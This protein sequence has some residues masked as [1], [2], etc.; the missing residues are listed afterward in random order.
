MLGRLARQSRQ[1]SSSSVEPSEPHATMTI[2][3]R[4]DCRASACRLSTGRR[5][6]CSRPPGLDVAHQVQRPHLR[7]M[8][9]RPG[10]VVAVERV[11]CVDVAADVAVA[12]MDAGALLDALGV[13]E[14]LALGQRC[15]G[16]PGRRSSPDRTRPPARAAGTGRPRRSLRRPSFISFMRSRP[17]IVGHLLHVHELGRPC[18]SAASSSSYVISA[19]QAGLE[20]VLGGLARDVGVD[21]RAAAHRRALRDRH[22]GEQP[23][24]E[25]AV[26]RFSGCIVVPDPRVAR[27]ARIGLLWSHRRPRSRTAPCSPPPPAGRR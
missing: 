26:A 2:R 20:H 18:R 13:D 21:E 10:E 5:K 1:R 27:L 17:L 24:I 19:G 12:Q 8:L 25:P 15:A 14:R 23:E 6:P 4:H 16:R 3:A 22:V 11:L 9:L 7:A